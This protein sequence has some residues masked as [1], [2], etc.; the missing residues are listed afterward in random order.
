MMNNLTLLETIL[1][2]YIILVNVLGVI[3][4]IMAR[5]SSRKVGDT[6]FIILLGVA[7]PIT[8]PMTLYVLTFD[9]W[10]RRKRKQDLEK[11]FDDMI[12]ENEK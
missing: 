1:I 9:K 3:A 12:K 5:Y 6:I 11:E 7:I 8:L 4:I 10:K 2:I